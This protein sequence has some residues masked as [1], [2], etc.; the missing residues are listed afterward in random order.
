[1]EISENI[2]QAS[3]QALK[4]LIAQPSY[5]QPAQPHA[6]W[7]TGINDALK[8]V[9][10]ICDQLGFK[11]YQDPDG[12]YG[13]A[14]VGSG[15]ETFGIVCHVDVVPVDRA[16]WHTDPFKAVVKDGWIYGRGAQDD[17]GPT[18]AAI[19][20]VKAL[21]DAGVKFDKKIRFIFETDEETLWRGMAQYNKKEAPITMGIA[22]DAEF[23]LIYAEKGLEQ[24]YLVGPGSEQLHLELKNAFNVVPDKAVYNGPKLTAVKQALDELGFA[25]QDDGDQ[26]VVLG[27]AVH[28]MKA[29][30]GTNAV[31]RLAMALDKV[32][33]GIP[34]LDFIGK[35]FKQDMTG[36][37]V[38]GD[39]A[40]EASGHLTFNISSLEINDK[41][42][43]MQIDLRIPVTIDHD[44]LIKK[45]DDKAHEYGLHY[46]K[47][48]YVAPL[49][50]PKDSQLVKTLMK[51]YQDATGDMQSQLAVSG[52]ATLAR[53]MHQCVAFGAM[54]PGTKDLMHQNDEA[55]PLAD[56]YKVMSIYADAIKE[57][58]T[59]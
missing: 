13:Y 38:L 49:Y 34:A 18:I 10:A 28:S 19:F 57:L 37:N 17:K 15:D 45:L 11:T 39:V 43:R 41:E 21:M 35:C 1:M 47:F 12:Y 26:I 30:E 3:L 23:P 31:L 14:D 29:P 25:Y 8:T 2:K 5:N 48:D 53:T 20:A 16:G 4:E 54:L 46:E 42:S 22:P 51:V 50:V 40:D 24:A 52:G 32:F 58:C 7:G 56:F 59:K 36:K 44:A 6:P 33:P 27:K 55:W 9:L